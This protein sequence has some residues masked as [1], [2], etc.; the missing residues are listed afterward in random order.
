MEDKIEFYEPLLFNFLKKKVKFGFFSVG[1]REQARIVGTR[2][3]IQT[4]YSFDMDNQT[5]VKQFIYRQIC[6]IFGKV[7]FRVL[8]DR[9][10][11][12]YERVYALVVRDAS[13]AQNFI[14]PV[15]NLLVG[16]MRGG[17]SL[18]GFCY[19]LQS[20][21]ILRNFTGELD[22]QQGEV[23]LIE[24]RANGAKTAYRYRTLQE[25]N[26]LESVRRL[27]GRAE[28]DGWEKSAMVN[29]NELFQ[30]PEIKAG[31]GVVWDRGSSA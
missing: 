29:S 22:T 26:V 12:G 4:E 7:Q 21:R 15:R 5:A 31:Q 13:H 17:E 6:P 25:Q 19:V 23:G 24:L 3:K 2:E 14:Y 18:S 8:Q 16:M 11:V 27:F 30:R 10:L 1:N 20:D 9:E 28:L